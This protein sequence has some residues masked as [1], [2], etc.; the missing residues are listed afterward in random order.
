MKTTNHKITAKLEEITPTLAGEYLA[1]NYENNRKLSSTRIET[2]AGEIRRNQ[3]LINGATICF[4]ESGW[5]TDGQH[6]LSAI[7][8]S[9][10]T[11]KSIV[12]RGLPDEA[13]M[14][15]DTGRS[16]SNADILHIS[17]ETSTVVLACAARYLISYERDKDFGYRYRERMS[18]ADVKAVL[19]K[20]P[21]L[22]DAIREVGHFSAVIK[23][24]GPSFISAF[25]YILATLNHNEA[26][27]FYQQ[28][29]FGEDLSRGHP[30]WHLRN[31]ILAAA[32]EKGRGMRFDPKMTFR[33]WAKTWNAFAKGER[34]DKLSVK[35]DEEIEPLVT[36]KNSHKIRYQ[37]PS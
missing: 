12:V 7:K 17:G 33:L 34:I 27:A 11:V 26:L 29:F 13:F 32:Q 18:A 28:L 31:Q 36:P 24:V 8:Q 21:G 2:L 1:K 6:R 20:H 14:T 4:T 25:F 22:R 15:I 35:D 23:R 3:W 9:N 19:H 37:I 30:V 5:L 10:K 16:R